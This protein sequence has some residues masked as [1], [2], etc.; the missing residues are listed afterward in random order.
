RYDAASIQAKQLMK[1]N[2]LGTVSLGD[3]QVKWYRSAH[4]YQRNG[5]WRGTWA[6][7]GGG[8]LMNQA[9][10]A[11]DLLA[12][13]IGPVESVRAYSARRFHAIEAE[14][15]AVAVMK[16]QSG[17]LGVIE[18]TTVAYPGLTT[19]L[20]IMGSRGSLRIEDDTLDYLYTAQPSDNMGDYGKRQPSLPALSL[21][22][23]GFAAQ[24]QDLVDSIDQQRPPEVTGEVARQPVELIQAIYRAAQTGQEVTLGCDPRA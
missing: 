23:V 9:I 2:A 6:M 21:P 14:D 17:A 22:L 13:L 4:Y 10:H 5:G 7:D 12:W 1:D 16:F 20:E 18:G 19:R 15:S 3:A 11:I 24:L 8:V